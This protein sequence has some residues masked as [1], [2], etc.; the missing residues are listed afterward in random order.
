MWPGR[1]EA[2]GDRGACSAQGRAQLQIGG[3]ARGGAHVEHI[4]HACDAGGVE[5]QRLVERRRG[6]SRVE[7]RACVAGRGI[8]V[9]RRERRLATAVHAA[10]KRGIDCRLG[11]CKAGGGAHVEHGA[12]ARDAGGVEAQR[13]VEHRRAVEHVDH[14]RDAGGVEAE[15]LVERRRILPSREAGMR[16]G[17]RYGPG[18]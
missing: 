11:V 12:H 15:R 7:R 5:A 4:A 2:A 18:A 16:R 13:L 1:R 14:A 3:R 17:K 9:G 8:Q 6:L 10:C